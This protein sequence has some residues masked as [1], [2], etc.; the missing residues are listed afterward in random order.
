MTLIDFDS[1]GLTQ[2]GPAEY[3]PANGHVYRG[4]GIEIARGKYPAGQAALRHSHP[5]EQV[6][7]VLS[8]RAEAHVGDEVYIVEAGQASHHPPNVEHHYVPLT[9][10]EFVSYKNG[11]SLK[12]PPDQS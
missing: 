1:I 11:F 9:E 3:Q 2:G 4:T 6:M 8:G 12:T 7:L 10:I 5:E